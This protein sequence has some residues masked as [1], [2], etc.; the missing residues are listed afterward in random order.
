MW[1]ADRIGL[2]TIAA[3]VQALH[4]ELGAWW[5]PAPLLLQ[6]ARDGRSFAAWQ[7]E[8]SRGG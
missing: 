2:K 5:E 8:R 3:R 1:M 7:A 6:L 4:A